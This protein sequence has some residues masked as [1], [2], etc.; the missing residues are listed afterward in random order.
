MI[1]HYGRQGGFLLDEGCT[2]EQMDKALEK[3]GFAMG[4][5]RLNVNGGTIAVGHPYGVSGQR[6]TGHE[7]SARTERHCDV[8]K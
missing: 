3:F 1:E 4:P 8:W 5:F 7:T 6:L 2:P